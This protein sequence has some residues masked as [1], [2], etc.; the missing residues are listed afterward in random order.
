MKKRI[1]FIISVVM[2]SAYVLGG[3]TGSLKQEPNPGHKNVTI[4][5]SFYPIYLH[6]INIAKDIPNVQVINMTEPQTGCLHDYQLIPNDLK[7]LAGADIF[8]INGGGMETFIDKALSQLEPMDMIDASKN[9]EFIHEED[10][11]ENHGHDQGEV[12]NEEG[13]H[14]H[15]I[16]P[17]VWVSVTGAIE[18]VKQIAK[19]LGTLDEAHKKA[20][21]EN[22]K[23]YIGKLEELSREMHDVLDQV[24]HKNI[25]TF[26]EAFPYFAQEFGLNIIGTVVVESGSEP[27]AKDLTK[28][29]EDIKEHNVKAIFSEPQYESKAAEVISKEAGV[30]LYTLDPIVTG[31]AREDQMDQYLI[32]MRENL[33]TLEE[34]LR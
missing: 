25:V 32:T 17:H 8:V 24:P 34:A 10:H 26:H 13:E 20:Y 14:D 15:E 22:A 7:K 12:H 31:E 1:I 23:V 16:N 27:S 3:C 2:L 4:V 28:I 5:T 19:E 18:Q 11:H 21:D 9:I 6:V 30:K 29:I 33:K